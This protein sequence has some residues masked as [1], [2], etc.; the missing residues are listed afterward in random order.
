MQVL[1][2]RFTCA[3]FIDSDH[4]PFPASPPINDLAGPVKGCATIGQCSLRYASRALPSE[5]RL[6]PVRPVWPSIIPLGIECH[7][8]P[9]SLF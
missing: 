6:A 9:V 7:P 4:I 2:S 3:K 8:L 1:R 5:V